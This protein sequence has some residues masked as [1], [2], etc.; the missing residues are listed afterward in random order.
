MKKIGMLIVILGLGAVGMYFWFRGDTDEAATNETVVTEVAED[1]TVQE[2]GKEFKEE[3]TYTSDD[4][5][6]IVPRDEAT[7][8]KGARKFI[9][10]ILLDVP[11]EK[12]LDESA[13]E[14]G[15]GVTALSMLLRYYRFDTTKN[16]LAEMLPTVPLEAE[17]G[18]HGDPTEAFVGNIASG[19]ALGVYASPLARIAQEVVGE[20]YHVIASE[21]TPFEEL[22]EQVQRNRPVWIAVSKDLKIPDQRKNKTWETENKVLTVPEYVHGVLIVGMDQYRV[23]VNDPLTDKEIEIKI[24]E[25]KEIYQKMGSQSLYLRRG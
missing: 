12:Q 7:E 24:D 25:M 9:K 2:P 18:L 11:M 8:V 5:I 17:N 16:E 10:T 1:E 21:M 4:Q 22:L 19:E 13:L 3:A 20:E 14:N 15:G 6:V 23:Y